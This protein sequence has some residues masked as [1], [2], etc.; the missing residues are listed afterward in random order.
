MLNENSLSYVG[1]SRAL[2]AIAL[3]VLLALPSSS[4]AEKPSTNP[5]YSREYQVKDT[6]PNV[7]EARTLFLMNLQRINAGLPPFKYSEE[8]AGTARSITLD[9]TYTD[10]T[11]YGDPNCN[12]PGF[13]ELV[14]GKS[15]VYEIAN[16]P[17]IWK[18]WRAARRAQFFD[19]RNSFVGLSVTRWDEQ[20]PESFTEVVVYG[21]DDDNLSDSGERGLKTPAGVDYCYPVSDATVRYHEKLEAGIKSPPAPWGKLRP[22]LKATLTNAGRTVRVRVRGMGR[23]GVTKV[24]MSMPGGKSI[25]IRVHRLGNVWKGKRR[26]PQRG[27]W[28]SWADS[29]AMFR[30][31]WFKPPGNKPTKSWPIEAQL[32]RSS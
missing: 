25:R 30:V 2:G 14:S 20:N 3:L 24:R 28:P 10:F 29:S 31:T 1:L 12:G 8:L 22:T 17:S 15:R 5:N 4:Q 13:A 18:P 27:G 26:L 7:T 16:P 9:G 32:R 6:R 23:K 19:P 11:S 21:T